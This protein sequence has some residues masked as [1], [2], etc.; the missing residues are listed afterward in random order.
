V[1]RVVT[2]ARSAREADQADIRYYHSLTAMERIA[3]ARRLQTR[4]F[5]KAKD[6]RECRSN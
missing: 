6:V 3:I 2:K 4:V 5:G 1:D